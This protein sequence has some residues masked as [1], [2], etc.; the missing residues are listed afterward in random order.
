MR[1]TLVQRAVRWLIKQ[2]SFG[3]LQ[4]DIDGLDQIPARGGAIIAGNHPSVL[5]GILLQAVAPRP[6]R[7]LVAEELYFHRFL[8]HGFK[9][10]H[11]VPVYRSRS[12]NGDALREAVAALEAGDLLGIFPEGTTRFLGTM[13]TMKRGVGLLALRTG[14][15][16]IP[17]AVRGTGESFPDG[18]RLPKP[19]R[20]R[21][22]F[23]PAMTFAKVSGTVVPEPALT[24]TLERIRA[25]VLELLD[26]LRAADARPRAGAPF[27]KPLQVAL[28][29]IIVLPL[30]GFLTGTANPDLDPAARQ[31]V[32]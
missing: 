21:L 27:W 19:G 7:F 26:Q 15:P 12:Q 5:D 32:S 25:C 14:A 20:V 23:G 24:A 22:R 18:Q 10:F 4:L 11:C 16:V 8:H 17:M 30:A 3:Y 31:T 2:L 1:P 9:A 28:S 6:V 13:P 29:A